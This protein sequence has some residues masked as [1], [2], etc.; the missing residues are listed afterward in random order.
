MKSTLDKGLIKF[1]GEFYRCLNNNF[2]VSGIK[3]LEENMLEYIERRKN[4]QSS[5]D[6]MNKTV[7]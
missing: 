2:S 5:N 3:V 7:I 4:G 6:F 1:S